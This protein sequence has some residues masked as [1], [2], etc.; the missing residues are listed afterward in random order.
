VTL[1]QNPAHPTTGTTWQPVR[2]STA[3][4]A[5]GRIATGTIRTHATGREGAPGISPRTLKTLDAGS[6]VRYGDTVPGHGRL[7]RP[8][9][10]GSRALIERGPAGTAVWLWLLDQDEVWVASDGRTMLISEMPPAYC[11]NVAAWLQRHAALIRKYAAPGRR[12]DPLAWIDGTALM[13]AL[14]E[15]AAD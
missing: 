8:T 2:V 6:M 13:R 11:G 1:T 15:S 14:V 5:L 10:A 12:M 4:R 9:R 3:R 7:I